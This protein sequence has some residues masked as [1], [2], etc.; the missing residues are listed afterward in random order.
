MRFIA[1]AGASGGSIWNRVKQGVGAPWRSARSAADMG[2]DAITCGGCG[3]AC[4]C[5]RQGSA[6]FSGEIRMAHASG[7]IL[8]SILV[9]GFA[10]TAVVEPATLAIRECLEIETCD[11]DQNCSNGKTRLILAQHRTTEGSFFYLSIGPLRKDAGGGLFHQQDWR[12]VRGDV[13]LPS[14]ATGHSCILTQGDDGFMSAHAFR[15]GTE[16]RGLRSS[17]WVRTDNS[18]QQVLF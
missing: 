3:V 7:R 10:G 1:S 13:P 17:D 8:A 9:I 16:V 5:N 4:D 2:C 12:W 18:Y 15:P 6:E 11:A 14:A